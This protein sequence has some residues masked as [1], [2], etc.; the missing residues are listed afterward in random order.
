MKSNDKTRNMLSPIHS[1]GIHPHEDFRFVVLIFSSLR[2]VF[3]NG[4][5]E[6][7]DAMYIFVKG[8]K[9]EQHPMVFR[10]FKQRV[11]KRVCVDGVIFP[12]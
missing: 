2:T 12:F 6:I 1:I 9:S 5:D 10:N 3:D 4:E 7:A 8:R 11:D